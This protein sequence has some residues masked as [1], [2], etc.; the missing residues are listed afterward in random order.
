[1]PQ[2]YRVSFRWVILDQL[3]LDVGRLR[4]ACHLTCQCG[5]A[6]EHIAYTNLAAAIGLTVIA[7]KALYHH[8]GELGLA[9]EEDH[10]IRDKYTIENNQNLVTAVNLVADINVVVFLGLAGVAGLTAQNQGNAFRVGR[11]GEGN[12]V[13]LVASRM[14]MVGITR[15]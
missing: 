12:R 6:D 10:V 3:V 11:A 9:V 13:V 5:S 4:R 15:T 2:Q 14:E 1:M 8:A 7:C